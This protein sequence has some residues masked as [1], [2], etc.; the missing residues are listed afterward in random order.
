[1]GIFKQVIDST[2][3]AQLDDI[4]QQYTGFFR[5][6]KLMEMLAQGIAEGIIDAPRDH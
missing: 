3:T 2:S 5:F 4:C 6:A 1:M